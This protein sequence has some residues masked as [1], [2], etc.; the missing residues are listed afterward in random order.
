MRAGHGDAQRPRHRQVRRDQRRRVSL[1]EAVR[2]PGDAAVRE[3]R[4]LRYPGDALGY[5]VLRVRVVQQR[6]VRVEPWR[7]QA[8]RVWQSAI[9]ET[10][11]LGLD[12]CVLRVELRLLG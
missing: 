9:E 3:T 11:K 8:Y 1:R 5:L 7:W 12:F 10:K 6:L 2:E 4:G